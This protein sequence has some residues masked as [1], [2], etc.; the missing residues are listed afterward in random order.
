[1]GSNSA[2]SRNI[3]SKSH[4]VKKSVILS[5]CFFICFVVIT[6][7]LL[8]RSSEHK[9]TTQSDHII[10]YAS[11]FL[12]ELTT[13]MSQLIP[14]SARVVSKPVRHS[15]IGLH[16]LMVSEHFYWLRTVS[17]IVLQQQAICTSL[18][19]RYILK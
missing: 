6:L 19:V 15:T 13:T 9:L 18:A 12:N 8:Y 5:L 10:S 7:S 2:F 17:L 3:L 1:M 11:Q 14:L 4:L 16:L